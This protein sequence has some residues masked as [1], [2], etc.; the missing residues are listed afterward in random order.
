MSSILIEAQRNTLKK[1]SVNRA[2]VMYKEINDDVERQLSDELIKHIVRRLE[3]LGESRALSSPMWISRSP[4]DTKDEPLDERHY[5]YGEDWPEGLSRYICERSDYKSEILDFIFV[6]KS[7]GEPDWF[8]YY[9][10][11]L[12]EED[13]KY[14]F[15]QLKQIGSKE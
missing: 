15:D 14:I 12:D 13:Y 10:Y 7:V 5:L 11:L 8:S 4:S 6:R 2:I 1:T 3:A 9:S